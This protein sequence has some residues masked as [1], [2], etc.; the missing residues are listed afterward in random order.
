MVMAFIDRERC[1]D[2]LIM[3]V[4]TIGEHFIFGKMWLMGTWITGDVK[5]EHGYQVT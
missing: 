5:W 3:R 1:D 2:L 4:I